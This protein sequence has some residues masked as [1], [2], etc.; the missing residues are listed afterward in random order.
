MIK[1]RVEN[2]VCLKNVMYLETYHSINVSIAE[3][4][5]RWTA[6]YF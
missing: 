5:G 1:D 4:L 6:K 3:W 2:Y